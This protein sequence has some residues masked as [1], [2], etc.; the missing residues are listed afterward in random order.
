MELL[1][2]SP[3]IS[4]ANPLEQKIF[5]TQ[6]KDVYALS[7]HDPQTLITMAGSLRYI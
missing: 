5:I 4:Q 3:S 2:S 6:G 1:F 7:T